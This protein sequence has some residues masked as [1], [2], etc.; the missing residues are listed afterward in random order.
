LLFWLS[1]PE[2]TCVLR[3]ICLGFR[4]PLHALLLSAAFLTA[5]LP[6][7]LHAQAAED[8]LSQKEVDTLRDT[9][10]VPTDRIAAFGQFLTDR[11]KHIAD[12]IAKRHG[13]TDYGGDMHDAIDQFGQIVDELNDNLDEYS[14]AHRDVRK[15]L[16]K[17][18][19]VVDEWTATLN[20]AAPNDAYNVVRKIALDNLK[21]TREI[22]GQLQ[23]DLDAY[24]KAHPEALKEEK[25]R[26]SNP[27]AVRPE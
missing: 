18:L 24:F 5:L 7:T 25:K 10:F 2:G 14:R 15:A 23:T 17:L 9:A 12:L 8:V 21:D 20:S 3:P 27:H 6:L 13:H 22:A 19:K 4:K 26:N 1:S 16:P 11:Q